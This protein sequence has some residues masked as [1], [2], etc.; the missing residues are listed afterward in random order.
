MAR[1][2]WSC[3]SCPGYLVGHTLSLSYEVALVTYQADGTH[4]I[5]IGAPLDWAA[6]VRLYNFRQKGS[7]INRCSPTATVQPA[8]RLSP[9]T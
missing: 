7:L 3:D 1:S 6:I 2:I 4:Q 8:S 5:C 9:P